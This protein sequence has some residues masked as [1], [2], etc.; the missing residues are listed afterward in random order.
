[1]KVWTIKLVVAGEDNSSWGELT[2]RLNRGLDVL[3]ESNYSADF[4]ISREEVIGYPDMPSEID[5]DKIID[6]WFN[7]AHEEVQERLEVRGEDST[8][9]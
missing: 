6:A 1:M 8:S 9:R 3:G 7:K 5:E 2:D 4:K